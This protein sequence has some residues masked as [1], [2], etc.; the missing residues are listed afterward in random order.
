M[1]K[2]LFKEGFFLLSWEMGAW[3]P[4][5]LETW[6]GF[7]ALPP[8]LYFG[9]QRRVVGGRVDLGSS[10][11]ERAADLRSPFASSTSTHDV[12]PVPTSSRPKVHD[13][14]SPHPHSL[15]F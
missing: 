4:S 11:S 2:L 5:I 13:V 8:D 3:L 10:F 1:V 12:N 15:T 6:Q 14:V 9:S 7:S